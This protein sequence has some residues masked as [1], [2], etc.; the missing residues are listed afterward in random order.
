LNNQDMKIIST[1]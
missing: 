1:C